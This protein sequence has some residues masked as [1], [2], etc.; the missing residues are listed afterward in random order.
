MRGKIMP[1]TLIAC[2]AVASVC[3]FIT[4]F[5]VDN[6]GS[7]QIVLTVVGFI[8]MAFVIGIGVIVTIKEGWK[9]LLIYI[10]YI[11]VVAPLINIVMKKSRRY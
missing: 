7:A 8:A 6:R 3:L 1:G 4:F 2:F 11:F 10:L 9:W 5:T